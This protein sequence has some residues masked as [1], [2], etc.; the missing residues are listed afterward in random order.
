M[1]VIKKNIEVEEGGLVAG[2]DLVR[3]GQMLDNATYLNVPD[4]IVKRDNTGFAELYVTK[5]Q[6]LITPRRIALVGDVTGSAMFDGSQ[7][8]N[9]KTSISTYEHNHD[10]LYY[11]KDYIDSLKQNLENQI[12][13][14]LTTDD[15]YLHIKTLSNGAGITPF[16]FN[17][18]KNVSISVS[19]GELSTDSGSSNNVARYDHHHNSMYY[20]KAEVN[21]GAGASLEV[22]GN[23][24]NLLGKSK[25]I[26][27]SIQ[28]PWALRLGSSVNSG[29]L[30][31]NS[32][33]LNNESNKVV[34]TSSDG[35]VKFGKISTVTDAIEDYEYIYVGAGDNIVKKIS[36][37]NFD[38]RFWDRIHKSTKLYK[39][40]YTEYVY[41]DTQ[42]NLQKILSSQGD[43]VYV[44]TADKLKTARTIS[45]TGDA[46]RFNNFWWLKKLKHK[47]YG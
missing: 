8:I 25:N 19:F 6:T 12:N 4:T 47:C 28:A 10:D 5:A 35:T 45:L 15:I 9:I 26:L 7:S 13:N 46:T 11:R 21:S 40:D 23:F 16:T 31:L 22:N 24:I 44:N 1:R 42:S 34:R 33:E 17:G 20:T 18:S 38:L 36:K 43:N 2:R 30:S 41:V 32:T 39:E 37:E 29:G 27:S 14:K 3:D